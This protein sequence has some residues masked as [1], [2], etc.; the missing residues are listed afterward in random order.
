VADGLQKEEAATI[1]AHLIED[2]PDDGS[3][4]QTLFEAKEA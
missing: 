3:Y 2:N 1:C 4:Y